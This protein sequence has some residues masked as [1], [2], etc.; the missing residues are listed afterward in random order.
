M[1]TDSRKI[2]CHEQIN[3]NQIPIELVYKSTPLLNG[4]HR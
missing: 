4:D 3:S 2:M 1:F